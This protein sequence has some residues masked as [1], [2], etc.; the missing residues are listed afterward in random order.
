MAYVQ[1]S[2]PHCNSSDAYTIYDDGAYCFSCQYTSKQKEEHMEIEE[3]SES[4]FTFIEDRATQ[5][6]HVRYRSM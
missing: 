5:Y 3:D 2:C 4:T 1:T 6:L